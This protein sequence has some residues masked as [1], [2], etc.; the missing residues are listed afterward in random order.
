[1]VMYKQDTFTGGPEEQG[2]VP[3][4]QNDIKVGPTNDLLIEGRGNGRIT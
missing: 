1:M 4:G 2:P 3:Q